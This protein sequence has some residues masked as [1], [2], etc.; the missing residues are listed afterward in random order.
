AIGVALSGG[1]AKGLAHIGILKAIDS[2]G[3][4]VNYV[5]GTSM[6]SIIGALYACG[7][8]PD[9]IE[10]IARILDWDL[11]LSNNAS[12][13][14]LS[15]DEKN[16]YARYAVELPW[17]NHRFQLYSGVIESE[18]IW[19]LLSKY[20][21]PV[22]GT[23]D[24]KK[25]PRGFSCI[26]TDVSS[27]EAVVLDSGDLVT[28]IRSSMAIPS[29]F[30]AVNYR[31]RKLVD[32]G[33]IRNFPVSDAK[34]LGAG[35][36][37]GS[38][39]AGG[40]LPQD[41]IN[42]VF[43]VMLQVAFFREND[44]AIKE[45]DLC[46]LYIQHQ[47][48]DYSMLSFSS[49]DEIIK[50][51]KK[52]GDSLY[53]R[54]KNIADSINALYNHEQTKK[55][56]LPL[57]DSVKI[58]AYEVR[59]L[60]YTN[61]QF[62]LHRL[63][64][65]N[66][67]SYTAQSLQMKIRRA[68]GT[69]YYNKIIYELQPLSDGTCKI[70]FT[71]EENPLTFAKLGITYHSFAGVSLLANIT[72]R[73][74]FTP[75]SRDLITV[76]LGENLRIKAEHLQTF[77]RFKTVTLAAAIEAENIAYNSY[78][79]FEKDGA[80]YRSNFTGDIGLRWTLNRNYQFSLGTRYETFHYKPDVPSSFYLRG[81]H[82][83]LT[84]YGAIK[85]NTLSNVV[86]PKRGTKLETEAGYL[87]HQKPQL[88]YYSYDKQLA[89]TDSLNLAYDD[90]WRV[91]FNMEHYQPL[92]RKLCLVSQAQAFMNFHQK[93]FVVNDFYAGG[94]VN[95][96]R[97]QILFTGLREGTVITGSALSAQLSFR[98]QMYS[99]LYL[100]A[101]ANA[102]YSNFIRSN[103]NAGKPEFLSGYALALGYNFVLGPLEISAM[104]CDQSQKLL[105]YINLGI[106]F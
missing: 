59:G 48:D 62:F 66:N 102:M 22:Y 74:F 80:F 12:L 40:L 96:F 44:D 67:Q 30:T 90:F 16:E 64:F 13:P 51:G 19:L 46:N 72:S 27:G 21:F 95:T 99:N 85:L 60:Q 8:S 33:I 7:Y 5:S 87:Y 94:L 23:K 34:K 79:N 1:G 2:A 91:K 97:N 26:S 32:G 93:S 58:T 45:K 75:Y 86:Y 35:Y 37:I 61:E 25:L 73:N 29:F 69:R 76:N 49:A 57:I 84:T 55:I 53:P 50:E 17:V 18:E 68:F 65:R 24:F 52:L 83:L 71:A 77:G 3:L 41:K 63:Q 31:G 82:S 20:F 70:I 9:S 6:G 54:L 10:K 36:I 81:N 98:Y 39:V 47:L 78:I 100:M 14:S 28:A 88:T 89:N 92:S 15:I 103:R 105:P 11:L 4:H 101:K 38:N 42:N 104:Y 43:Q 56:S 106:P